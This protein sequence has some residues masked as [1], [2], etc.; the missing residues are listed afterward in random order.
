MT[1]RDTSE[2]K[3][4]ELATVMPHEREVVDWDH[5]RVA[6]TDPQAD[7]DGARSSGYRAATKFGRMRAT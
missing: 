2:Y 5:P 6:G 7:E 4:T 3:R 1:D